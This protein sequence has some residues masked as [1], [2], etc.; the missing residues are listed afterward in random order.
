MTKILIVEDELAYLKLLESQLSKAGYKIVTAENGKVGLEKFK[1]E[2]PDL[3]LL[4]IK[5]PIMDGIAMLDEVRKFE[6]TTDTKVIMLTNLEPNDQIISE[7]VIEQP[8]YYFVK[9][10]IN[11]S[12]LLKKIK[13]LTKS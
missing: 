9:S 5:M 6:G 4:D 7:I 13:E 8:A 12:D 10:D 11:I 3:V 2:N 1:K